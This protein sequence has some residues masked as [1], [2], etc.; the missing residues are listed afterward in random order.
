MRLVTCYSLGEHCP[1]G[2]VQLPVWKLQNAVG[3]GSA[4][5]SP[6]Q[7]AVHWVRPA[8]LGQVALGEGLGF[9]GQLI[10]VAANQ[11]HSSTAHTDTVDVSK[12]GPLYCDKAVCLAVHESFIGR[13]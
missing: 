5:V 1:D 10:C 2:T 8:Q 13:A 6:T 9:A 7:V 3:A 12:P 4:N 11:T